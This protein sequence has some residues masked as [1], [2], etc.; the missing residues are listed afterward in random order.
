MHFP[1]LPRFKNLNASAR[2]LTALACLVLAPCAQALTITQVF[3][4]TTSGT[5]VGSSVLLGD[6]VN[7][8]G[9]DAATYGPLQAVSINVALETNVSVREVN[10]YVVGVHMYTEAAFISAGIASTDTVLTDAVFTGVLG[11]DVVLVNPGDEHTF[12]A[13]V[14]AALNIQTSDPL[15]LANFSGAGLHTLTIDQ[16]AVQGTMFGTVT[17]NST[18]TTTIVYT[19]GSGPG[20]GNSVPEAGHSMVLLGAVCGLLGYAR[21]RVGFRHRQE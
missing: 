7:Y 18:I 12:T 1:L 2:K 5:A 11:G 6:V 21:R 4:N 13:L 17:A 8:Q 16:F 3:S 19:Y 15:D 20:T 14:K 10:G 9:F